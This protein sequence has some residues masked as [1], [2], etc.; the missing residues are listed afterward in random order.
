MSPQHESELTERRIESYFCNEKKEESE[1]YYS[2]REE[3]GKVEAVERRITFEEMEGMEMKEEE[4]SAYF[5]SPEELKK[6]IKD[7]F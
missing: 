1:T 6:E 4:K 2:P 7:V 3:A 5:S